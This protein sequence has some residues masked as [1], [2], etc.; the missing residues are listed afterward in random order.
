MTK[1]KAIQ[2]AKNRIKSNTKYI[3]DLE[4]YDEEN[5]DKSENQIGTR[6]FKLVIKITSSENLLLD[7]IIAELK[8][9]QK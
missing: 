5:P 7:Q 4:K 2:I 6:I 3:N 8:S 1:A 9:N